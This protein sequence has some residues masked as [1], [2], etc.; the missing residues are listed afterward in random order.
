MSDKGQ[1]FFCGRRVLVL[2]AGY[3]GGELA[4]RAH[5]AG[6]EVTALT[7]NADTCARLGAVGIRTLQAELASEAWHAPAGAADFVLVSVGAGASTPEAYRRSY[8]EGLLS[9]RRW[10]DSLAQS[11]QSVGTLVYTSSTSVYPQGGGVL[12]TEESPIEA[13]GPTP[14]GLLAEAEALALAAS[15]GLRR[16]F[17]LRLA[18]IYGPGRHG[19][20]DRL[21]SDSASLPGRPDNHLNLIHRDDIIAA[22]FACWQASVSIPGQ[23]LNVADKGRATRR[24]IASWLAV[25]LGIAEPSF[26]GLP[27]EGRR[28]VTPDRIVSSDRIQALLGWQ[29]LYHTFREGYEKGALLAERA[30]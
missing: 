28:R 25:R 10:A 7:R 6:A 23:V 13:P 15:P 20:L 16:S 5:A 2:G 30:S 8:V 1:A 17:V 3:V 11:G 19:F 21:L 4:L 22:V 29:P 9:V 27:L 18:G 24:E 12:V 26:T 14:T